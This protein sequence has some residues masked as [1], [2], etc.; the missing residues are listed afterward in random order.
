MADPES[1]QAAFY[2]QSPERVEGGEAE[3][4]K[5]AI[6]VLSPKR[7]KGPM[8]ASSP[9]YSSEEEHG[10][11]SRLSST[12]NLL[13]HSS[14]RSYGSPTKNLGARPWTP[15]TSQSKRAESARRE[16][17]LA[18]L[19]PSVAGPCT[20]S[21]RTNFGTNKKYHKKVLSSGYGTVTATPPKP[22][23]LY[24]DKDEKESTFKPDTALSKK[25]FKQVMKQDVRSSGYGKEIVEGPVREAPPEEPLPSFTPD[26]TLTKK[27]REHVP[28]SGY[29]KIVPEVVVATLPKDEVPTFA[30]DMSA[31]ARSRKK[32]VSSAYGVETPVKHEVD[33]KKY[34]PTFQPELTLG[35]AQKRIRDLVPSKL[36]EPK[37]VRDDPEGRKDADAADRT[38]RYTLAADR[39]EPEPEPEF[40]NDFVLDG[41]M[42]AEKMPPVSPFPEPVKPTKMGEQIKAAAPSSG[43]GTEEYAPEQ[44]PRLEKPEEPPQLAFGASSTYVEDRSELPAVRPAASTYKNAQPAYGEGYEP[45]HN[46]LPDSIKAIVDGKPEITAYYGGKGD[47]PQLEELPEPPRAPLDWV[48]SS[49][50]GFVHPDHYTKPREPVQPA[51]ETERNYKPVGKKVEGYVFIE[52]LPV[53]KPKKLVDVAP[54]VYIASEPAAEASAYG[55]DDEERVT[56]LPSSR[57]QP[58][59]QPDMSA[60]AKQRLGVEGHYGAKYSPATVRRMIGEMPAETAAANGAA[61]DV[62][63]DDHP[64]KIPVLRSPRVTDENA[65][66]AAA[67]GPAAA[68]AAHANGVNAAPAENIGSAASSSRRAGADAAISPDDLTINQ[69]RHM[70]QERTL[71]E[72]K[73]PG[74][75]G[76]I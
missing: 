20:F 1:P 45:V 53:V 32:V 38:L 33:T 43:Y 15:G 76:I 70:W 46:P 50:Y 59:F 47:I 60:T 64:A 11:R 36:L 14:P 51:P 17:K 52:D 4:D 28:A 58:T 49:G 12:S 69:K 5:V 62:D 7:N 27:A 34:T 55:D 68:A 13:R 35:K 21:P 39:A 26:M 67:G 66:A 57:P 9:G 40:E 10:G 25:S 29:G 71:N 42:L 75:K 54:R 41:S 8:A 19:H 6:P 2:N 73:S 30:P 48:P 37:P 18:G 72:G 44:A 22:E 3:P 65:A 24:V 31:T 74:R 23:V 56:I 16:R 61:G 63:E